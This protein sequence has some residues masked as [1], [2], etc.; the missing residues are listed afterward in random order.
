MKSICNFHN[1]NRVRHTCRRAGSAFDQG[2]EHDSGKDRAQM[3]RFDRAPS[4]ICSQ[5]DRNAARAASESP[6]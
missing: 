2:K 5:N 4:K 1:V 6:R 3:T